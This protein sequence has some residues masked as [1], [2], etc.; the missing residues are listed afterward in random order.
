MRQ[1]LLHV[2]EVSDI[3]W[4]SIAAVLTAYL[5]FRRWQRERKCLAESHGTGHGIDVTGITDRVQ[6]V[7]ADFASG[8]QSQRRDTSHCRGL[9]ASAR[10]AVGLLA[11]FRRRAARSSTYTE[12]DTETHAA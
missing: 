9:L 1:R 3:I 7:R 12:H 6:R 4:L 2:M 5:L 11:Y 8:L 10:R